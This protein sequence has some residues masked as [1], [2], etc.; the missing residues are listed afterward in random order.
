[1]QD[2]VHLGESELKNITLWVMMNIFSISFMVM[3]FHTPL[4][5]VKKAAF[6]PISSHLS[7]CGQ[8]RIAVEVVGKIA[9]PNLCPGPDN[10][11]CL[12]ELVHITSFSA[13]FT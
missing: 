1:L 4:R 3:A 13:S 10:A 8:Q 5:R 12:F 11:D 7:C 6:M 9:R 2:Q